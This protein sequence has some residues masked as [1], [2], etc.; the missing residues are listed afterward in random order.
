ML[1]FNGNDVNPT[2]VTESLFSAIMLFIGIF[3]FAVVIAK[4][5]T[6]ILSVDAAEEARSKQLSSVN[7]FLAYRDVPVQLQHKIQS[8]YNYLWR[9]GQSQYHKNAFDELP[10]MLALQLSLCT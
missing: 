5:S 9:S 4:T 7:Q 3:F 2:N 10:P 1:V 6:L 8:Y